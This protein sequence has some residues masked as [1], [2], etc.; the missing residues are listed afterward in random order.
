M[1][2]DVQIQFGV[3]L[4]SGHIMRKRS[5]DQP[6]RIHLVYDVSLHALS[7]DKQQLVKVCVTFLYLYTFVVS[8]PYV[9]SI[10]SMFSLKQLLPTMLETIVRLEV[11]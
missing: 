7:H 3:R 8:V 11:V 2:D 4:E 9:A 10:A 1:Y 6:L 5:I